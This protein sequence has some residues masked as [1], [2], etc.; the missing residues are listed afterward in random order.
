MTINIDR[1]QLIALG[2]FGL[3]ALSV[4][5][6]AGLMHARGFTH[7]VASGEPSQTSVLLW[8]RYVGGDGAKLS[9]EISADAD[10]TAARLVG[11]V[12]TSPVRDHIAKYVVAGLQP[13][14]WYF[15]RFIAPD[16]TPSPVGRTR[17]L[18]ADSISRFGLGV[19]SCSNLPFGY[20]NAYAHAAQRNDLD[21]MIHTG[22]YIYE[23]PIG[24]Y[25]SKEQAL[26]GRMIAPDHEIIHVA[27]YRLRYA[28]YRSDPDLQ[29]LHQIFPMIGMW[30]DHETANDA[31]KTG[32]QNHQPETEGEWSVRKRVAEQVYREWMPVRDRADNE[33]HWTE[34]QVG[35]L[36]TIFLT[37]SRISGRDKPADLAEALRG[38]TDIPPALA[39]FRDE[40]WQEP[41]RHMLGSDQESWL[42]GAMAKSK[43][44]GT[45]WQVWAQ[46]CIMGSL[47]APQGMVNWL[48]P[49]AAP[50]VKARV[51]VGQM[52]AA[53]GL[54]F[55]MDA[56]DGYPVARERILKS[57]ADANADLVVLAGDSH[58]GWAFNL[59][60]GGEPVGVEFAG[61][62]VTSPGF[63]S[64]FR[65]ANAGDI[66]KA[67]LETNGQL[68]WANTENRGY[69]SVMLT[70]DMAMSTWHFLDTVRQRSPRM[71]GQTVHA[72]GLGDNRL[73]MG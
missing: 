62:S 17:T 14:R 16:G 40:V 15:Y 54:P 45:K 60:V 8:T 21:L 25:P 34:Y 52:A 2:T 39:R 36:A 27:D 48:D 46:Q 13:G 38:Q 51:Q 56:W 20:F 7:N 68:H 53:A 18:P 65:G 61:Q 22:D 28:A 66:S 50:F 23:Y 49:N 58:N 6:S 19:F 11:E 31:Y 30:D 59:D 9:V 43:A 5:A 37:E 1:R 4:P 71:K 3:G 69:M 10:F 64:F 73:A 42:A 67:L 63:E 70:P 24:T 55:N 41:G 72:A 12:S 57:I 26:A 29:R 35:D 47:R 44:G 33:P 32:A